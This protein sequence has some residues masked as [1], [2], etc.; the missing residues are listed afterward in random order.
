[1]IFV[2]LLLIFFILYGMV[3]DDLDGWDVGRG[4]SKR[5]GIYVHIELIHFIVSKS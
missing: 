3:C 5:A 4:K 1:M 2:F